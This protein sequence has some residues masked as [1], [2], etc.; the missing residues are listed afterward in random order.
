MSDYVRIEWH[1]EPFQAAA[2]RLMDLGA[3]LAPMMA[4]IAEGLLH[5]TQDRFRTKVDPDGNAWVP[6]K[7][8]TLMK[9]GTGA[10]IL[11]D[12]GNLSGDGLHHSWGNDFAEVAATPPYAKWQ[13]EGTDPYVILPK[14]GQAL[15]FISAGGVKIA[16]KKV[17]HSGL[18]ARKFIGVSPEDNEMIQDK[19]AK[20]LKR[21]ADGT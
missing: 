7:P 13:Q 19:A 6:L 18:P 10:G 5:S 4:D 17:N 8:S 20:A 1:D 9:R 11:V 21:A 16:R 3:N 12:T 2:K 15:G 14:K